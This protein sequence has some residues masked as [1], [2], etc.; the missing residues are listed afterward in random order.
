MRQGVS[1]RALIP[2]FACAAVAQ[3]WTPLFDGKTLNGWKEAMDG[4]KSRPR[5]AR[6][7]W[8]KAG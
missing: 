6:S 1:R 7:G 8:A 5:A 2:A 4:G 3:E